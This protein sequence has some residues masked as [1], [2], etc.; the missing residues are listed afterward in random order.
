M[1]WDRIIEDWKQFKKK[2]KRVAHPQVDLI[3]TNRLRPPLEGEIQEPHH[4]HT[5][6]QVRLD[7]DSWLP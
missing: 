3:A 4:G 2:I 6:H 7:W 5:K 1:A